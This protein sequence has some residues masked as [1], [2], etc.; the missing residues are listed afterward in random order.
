MDIND[1]ITIKVKDS[2]GTFVNLF[3]GFVT[4][5]DVEVTQASSTAISEVI[6][7]TAM[8]ALSKLP[9]ALTTGVLSK[10]Y[11]GN[12]IYTILSQV[13]FNTWNEVPAG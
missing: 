1:Q 8:G 9:K 10:D 12:Q 5:I 2:T 6:Q 3:G 4:D 11:D 7:V 13:L